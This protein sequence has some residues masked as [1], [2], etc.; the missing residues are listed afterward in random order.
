MKLVTKPLPDAKVGAPWRISGKGQGCGT[1][2]GSRHLL[3]VRSA[4]LGY[5]D[6]GYDRGWLENY[7]G[8]R[9][10]CF[11][12]YL[13]AMGLVLAPDDTLACRCSYQNQATVALKEHGLRPPVVEPVPGQRNFAYF[14]RSKEPFFTGSLDVR[15][16]H[17]REGLDVRYTLDGSHPDATSARYEGPLTI[18]ETTTVRAAV[19]RG[20]RKLE[21][22][23]AVVFRKVDDI[24]R[25]LKQGTKR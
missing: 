24:K 19:F 1:V 15:I 12:N 8:F 13:P 21:Q 14:P 25:V 17:E 2:A 10:G 20:G 22:K 23:D 6:L 16:W 5:Y 11:I 4:T 18:S 7:G 3:L 9:V